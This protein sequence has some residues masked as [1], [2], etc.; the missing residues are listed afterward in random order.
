MTQVQIGNY[1]GLTV[2][3]INR[4]LRSL[5]DDQIINL[6]KHCVTIIDLAR[7]TSLARNE[8]PV[9]SKPAIAEVVV[10]GAVNLFDRGSPVSADW[11]S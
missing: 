6:E 5:R 4:V 8:E 3:H 1:L 9:Q 11:A 10:N 7:L 2:V